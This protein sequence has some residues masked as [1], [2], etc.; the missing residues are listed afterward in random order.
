MGLLGILSLLQIGVIPGVLITAQIRSLS[1]QDRTLL[2][3][4]LSCITNYFLVIIL[5]IFGLYNQTT[6]IAILIVEVAALLFFA[7]RNW[8]QGNYALDLSVLVDHERK[9]NPV[10]RWLVIALLFFFTILTFKQIGTVFT[11]GDVVVSWNKWAI[12]WF[13]GISPRNTYHYPQLI[14]ALYSL[15]YQ[16]MGSVEVELFAKLIPALFPLMLMLTFLR[17]ASLYNQKSSLYLLVLILF[18]FAFSRMMGSQSAFNGYADLPLAYF[19]L[20]AIYIFNLARMAP[21]TAETESNAVLLVLCAVVI[22]GG[23]ITKHSALFLAAVMPLAWYFHFRHKTTLRQIVIAYLVMLVVAGHW[24]IYKQ[25]QIYSGAD[26]SNLQY[27]SEIVAL[28]WYEKLWHGVVMVSSK[29]SWMWIPIFIAGL[30]TPLGRAHAVWIFIPFFL[31]WAIFA[32]YDYRNLILALP[33]LAFIL[34][35]GMNELH[36]HFNKT[37]TRSRI[38]SSF[39]RVVMLLL[40]SVLIYMLGTPKI[41]NDLITLQKIS[42]R[43]TGVPE[44]NEQLYAFFLVN[45][46]PSKIASTYYALSFL[47]G[48]KDRDLPASCS[49]LER[50]ADNHTVRYLIVEAHCPEEVSDRLASKY[51]KRLEGRDL[52]FYE[53]VPNHLAQRSL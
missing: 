51:K 7:K 8:L 46:E 25:I 39:S 13:H 24:F 23:A 22:A 11:D 44:F 32:S 37:R 28:P 31:L 2:I 30:L 29:I 40:L 18:W 36:G 47:P 41:S 16:F 4:P 43:A 10:I 15:N 3:L 33:S 53:V 48:L 6:L 1:P 38:Y 14:P 35:S 21:D 52:I 42:K 9:Q 50:L 26:S 27:L 49:D 34:A 20:V 5:T 45:P 12:D 19:V 17:M